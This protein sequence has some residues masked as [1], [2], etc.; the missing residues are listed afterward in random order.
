MDQ[1]THLSLDSRD[2]VL[3]N[4]TTTKKLTN[5]SFLSSDYKKKK[6]MLAFK[7]VQNLKSFGKRSTAMENGRVVLC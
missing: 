7:S 4:Y 2:W 5:H 3:V 6:D 1:G